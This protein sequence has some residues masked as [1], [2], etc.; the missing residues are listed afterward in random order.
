MTIMKNIVC[1]KK[2]L[3]DEDSVGVLST[4]GV[5]DGDD[6]PSSMSHD[7]PLQPDSHLH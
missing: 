7:S 2:R 4:A 5:V 6:D 1:W 3:F